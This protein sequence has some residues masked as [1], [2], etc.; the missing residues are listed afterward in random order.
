MAKYFA[1]TRTLLWNRTAASI[2]LQSTVGSPARFDAALV[3]S[4]LQLPAGASGSPNNQHAD[5]VIIPVGI[6]ATSASDLFLIFDWLGTSNQSSGFTADQ[7]WIEFLDGTGAIIARVMFTSNSS[8]TGRFQWASANGTSFT[9]AGPQV[10]PVPSTAA[11]TTFQLRFRAGPSGVNRFQ[12]WQNGGQVMDISNIP[13][14]ITGNVAAVRI[15][16]CFQGISYLS[17]VAMSDFDMRGY[18]FPTDVI[19]ATGT[20][21]DGT[22]TPAQTADGDFT[23][24]KSLPASGNLYSG[25]HTAR[26]LPGNL[27]IESVTIGAIM[28]AGGA[29]PNARSVIVAGG[30]A[31]PAAANISPALSTGYEW[32]GQ[33]WAN[34]PSLGPWTLANY[35]AAE[36]GHEARAA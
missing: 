25:T 6:D 34:H 15:R 5:G 24:S 21:N 14:A 3:A 27:S 4:C 36:K 26:T 9:Q 30:V 2:V 8:A 17:Q 32:R 11:L 29:V 23:T 10:I 35:N 18:R 12:F 7:P 1:G 22:G 13:L 20:F 28:R 19:N 16:N 31:Y 33:E